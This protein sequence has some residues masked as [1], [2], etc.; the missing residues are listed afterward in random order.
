VILP[1]VFFI[2]MATAAEAEMK[3]SDEVGRLD[4][5]VPGV[6]GSS[7]IRLDFPQK[8]V[9]VTVYHEGRTV[10]KLDESGRLV[11]WNE[12]ELRRLAASYQAGLFETGG[13]WARIAVQILDAERELLSKRPQ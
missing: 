5:I 4:V 1:L 9:A 12:S 2:M 6:D 10:A 7:D 8:P 11:E 13:A 3:D